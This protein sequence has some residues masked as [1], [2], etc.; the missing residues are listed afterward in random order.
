LNALDRICAACG[1]VIAVIL[2]VFGQSVGC[3]IRIQKSLKNKCKYRI[4]ELD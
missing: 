2:N 3:V 4:I 1:T